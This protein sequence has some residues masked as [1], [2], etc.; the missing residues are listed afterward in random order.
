[1]AIGLHQGA[2]DA[3]A[4]ADIQSGMSM[5]GLFNEFAQDGIT[6]TGTTQA[7]AF[8]TTGQTIRVATAGASSGILLPPAATGL[9]VLVINHGANALQVY[10]NGIDTI[11]DVATATGVN[12]M[13][14]SLV[15]YTCATGASAGVAGKWYSEGLAT[16]F[17]GSGLQTLSNQDGLTAKAGGGQGGGPAINRM[18]NRVATVTTAA[19]SVTLPASV[20]GLEI[21]IINGA[22]V[23][24]MN[25]FPATGETIN[26]LAANTAIAV[27]AGTLL[28]FFCTT[29]G[30]WW[31]K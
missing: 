19:D 18:I 15:I 9:E 27:A 22:A 6:A 31:T 5:T 17:G 25:V 10:G 26:L 11:D 14:N 20:A 29:A 24:S 12:Q 2:Y 4:V 30:A 1:M 13:V 28:V 21:T 23:N 3:S 16:G 8:Q 7:T